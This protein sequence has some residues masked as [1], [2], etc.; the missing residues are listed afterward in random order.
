MMVA[1]LEK[2]SNRLWFSLDSHGSTWKAST[3]LPRER[4]AVQQWALLQLLEVVYREK[5]EPAPLVMALSKEH[6]GSYRQRL[7]QLANLL[8]KQTPLVEAL[9]QTP[10]ALPEDTVLALRLA[11]QSG[12]LPATFAMLSEVQSEAAR[13]RGY[14]WTG[15]KGYWLVVA[16][17]MFQ[18]LMLM[19]IF[20]V[21]TFRKLAQES[22]LRVVG[23]FG[24]VVDALIPVAFLLF[25]CLCILVLLGWASSFR[26]WM[27]RRFL[28]HAGRGSKE[29]ELGPEFGGLLRMLSVN[30]ACGRP[31]S[32]ALSTLA[33]YHPHPVVRQR[34][35]LARNEIEQGAE[36]WDSLRDAKVVTPAEFQAL[37]M[38]KGAASEAWILRKMAVVRDRTWRARDRWWGSC[39]QPLTVL[40]FGVLVGTLAYGMFGSLY[41]IVRSLAS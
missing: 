36:V 41:G 27:G 21:P 9:E 37:R 24:S 26:R 5:L 18:M 33:K 10:D 39:L 1:T 3:F 15:M 23:W 14:D 32:G 17:I 22:G 29:A 38:A 28:P 2:R 19:S 6:R 7:F 35:L 20:I 16:F 31:V 25:V 13:H 34:L 8:A 30:L 12:T 4:L 40:I 11:S